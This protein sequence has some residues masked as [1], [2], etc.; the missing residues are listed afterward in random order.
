M[1]ICE[2]LAAEFGLTKRE[3]EQLEDFMVEAAKP[4][5]M[6]SWL[7]STPGAAP[8]LMML[9]GPPP[10][11]R[12][13][14][15]CWELAS[16]Q[17]LEP[18]ATCDALIH[19]YCLC[20]CYTYDSDTE[21]EMAEQYVPFLSGR[22]V[23]R[24]IRSERASQ[25]ILVPCLINGTRARALLDCGSTISAISAGLV[26][27]LELAVVPAKGRLI[28]ADRSVATGRRGTVQVEVQI[29]D[30]RGS[31]SLELEVMDLA[32]E[33]LFGLDVWA[34]FNF[35]VI[36]VPTT[37]PQAQLPQPERRGSYDMSAV[38]E[39]LSSARAYTDGLWDQKFRVPQEDLRLLFD[40]I[41]LDL[42]ANAGIPVGSFC[43]HEAA[44]VHLDTGDAAPVFRPQYRVADTLKEVVSKQVRAWVD[45]GV[46]VPAPADVQWNSPLLV[47]KKKDLYGRWTKHRVCIDPRAINALLPDNMLAVPRINE[48]FDRLR[49]ARV[50]TALDLLHS[51]H[52]FRIAPEDC[53][54]TAFS[55]DGQRWMFVGAPFGFKHLTQVFQNVFERILAECRS[56]TVSYVDDCLIFSETM[57]EHVL[58]VQ[59]VLRVLNRYNLRLNVDKCKFGYLRVTLLGHVVAAGTRSWTRTS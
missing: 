47:A 13:C 9:G 56:F 36:N 26:S 6:L 3:V 5:D 41:E 4:T 11:A 44:V 52:Q 28:L 17:D 53:I 15:S 40:A 39:D 37:F 48:L 25:E 42:Q 50:F 23:L 38:D 45:Q 24:M 14:S 19:A 49:G 51:Y 32:N 10:P 29:A 34:R 33:A 8:P 30:G 1:V 16:W 21:T 57:E 27:T 58:H 12:P 20:Q 35:R 43:S 59:S 31:H 18:C 7:V 54:K 46:V 55:W 2:A 22:L